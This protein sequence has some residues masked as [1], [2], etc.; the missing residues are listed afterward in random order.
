MVYNIFMKKIFFILCINILLADGFIIPIPPRPHPRAKIYM[1][2]KT[3]HVKIKTINRICR[4]EVD[5]VFYNPYNFRIEGEY[6]FPLPK[7]AMP[8]EFS[9]FINGR[10][11]KGEVLE[12]EKARKIYEQIVRRL[13]DPA[14]LEYYDRN[15]FRAKVFPIEPKREV[16]VKIRYE[17]ELK[18]KGDFYE[19]F[20]PFKIEGISEKPV[21]D[22]VISF[23]IKDEK[24]IKLCFSPTHKVDFHKKENEVIGAYEAKNVKPDKDFILYYSV[25]REKFDLDLL[26]YKKDED[27]F[28]LLGI[29]TPTQPEKKEILPKDIAFV[30]D[31]SG[32]MSG[33][34]IEQAKKGLLFF[35]EHLNKEDRF[36][37]ISFSSDIVPFK[38]ELV[39]ASEENIKEAKD[40]IDKLEAVGGTNIN[41]ALIYTLELFKNK[42]P[43]Y[44]LFLTDGLPTVGETS[45][46]RI[47]KNVKEKLKNQKI[48]VFGVGYDVNTVFLDE[49]SKEGKGISEYIEPNENLEIAISSLYSKIMHPAIEDVKVEF[50]NIEVYKL[51]P[52]EI[53]DL[54]YGQDVFIAGRYRNSGTGQ[55]V[56]K[57]AKK[58]EE[59]VFEKT[60]EFPERNEEL[61]FIPVIWAR[62]RIAYL[63]SQIRIHGENKEL[64]DE[65]EKLG[66]KYGIVTPYTSY[67]VREKERRRITLG[68]SGARF[69]AEKKG[70]LA[71]KIAKEL[72]KMEEIVVVT[73]PEIESI[74]RI[75]TKVFYLKD[76]FYVDSE[77]REGMKLIEIKFGSDEYFDLIRKYPEY[78]K[79]LSVGENLI[80]VIENIA[81]RIKE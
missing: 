56:I 63:L 18:R 62:K 24:P 23:E 60:L 16:R 47:L 46:E 6:I 57:G 7:G 10:E 12:K 80:V 15:L 73:E 53:G 22:V 42:R 81:Y 45:I 38:K 43:S 64:V 21:E 79:Y 32:S 65:V 2:L 20:Y 55:V 50:N 71:I 31:V 69:K 75:G 40:F 44:V 17:Y 19:I 59:F 54:F 52:A 11:V 33:E 48:F 34:K 41:S 9:L 1:D 37:I 28:F 78:A 3:H 77:Y 29:S 4:V 35:V 26:S 74:K 14:L 72:G 13:K 30:I 5:E 25:S 70:K 61:D 66:K 68:I 39:Y 49:L 51:H 36:N 58:E 76:G 67:L 8:S 27:G